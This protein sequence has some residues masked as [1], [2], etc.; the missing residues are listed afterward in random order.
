MPGQGCLLLTS[1]EIGKVA[2]STHIGDYGVYQDLPTTVL[3]IADR[4]VLVTQFVPP[5]LL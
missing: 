3:F 2:H 1:R 5:E 4:C